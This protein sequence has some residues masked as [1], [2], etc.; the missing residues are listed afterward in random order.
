M[1]VQK[2]LDWIGAKRYKEMEEDELDRRACLVE[3]FY[4]DVHKNVYTRK[5][6]YRHR[7]HMTDSD[8]LSWLRDRDLSKSSLEFDEVT[9]NPK[10]I[11]SIKNKISKRAMIDPDVKRKMGGKNGGLLAEWTWMVYVKEDYLIE[12]SICDE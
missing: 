6:W 4:E 11:V 10:N 2:F 1:I 7:S 9:I 3:F 8:F 5:A 12:D